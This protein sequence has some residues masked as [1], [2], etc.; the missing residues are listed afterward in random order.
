MWVQIQ[1]W[2]ELRNII[3]TRNIVMRNWQYSMKYSTIKVEYGEYFVKTYC[4]SHI[5]LLW[6]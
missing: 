2:F 6:I 4:R 1:I 5:T 3:Q